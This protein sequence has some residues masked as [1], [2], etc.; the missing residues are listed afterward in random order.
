VI[1][2][3]LGCPQWHAEYPAHLSLSGL[4]TYTTRRDIT[5]ADYREP[6]GEGIQT[7]H[8]MLFLP[9]KKNQQTLPE[10]FLTT[11]IHRPFGRD[12]RQPLPYCQLPVV[13]SFGFWRPA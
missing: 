10:T 6:H 12:G 13:S 5:S 1:L 4:R 7:V 2:F 3:Q 9:I 11:K 8:H